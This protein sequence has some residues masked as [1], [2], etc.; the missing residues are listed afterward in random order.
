MTALRLG[1]LRTKC[2]PWR[3]LTFQRTG[4][5]D[6]SSTGTSG[7]L[8]IVVFGLRLPSRCHSIQIAIPFSRL[9]SD[10]DISPRSSLISSKSV[11]KSMSIS[12][13]APARAYAGYSHSGCASTGESA[14]IEC[15][16]ISLSIRDKSNPS[17]VPSGAFIFCKSKNSTGIPYSVP[18]AGMIATVTGSNGL[19][20]FSKSP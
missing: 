2:T 16:S 18:D 4:S 6:A 5:S 3:Q 15:C 10:R 14:Y 11:T 17:H 19:R 8:D 13:V 20:F 9:G 12:R 7:P 1:K